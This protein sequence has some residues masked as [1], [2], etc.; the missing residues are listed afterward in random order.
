MNNKGQTT[1]FFTLI[2][3]ILIEITFTAF[4]VS[5]LYIGKMKALACV[6]SMR[7]SIM[8]DYDRELF[9]QYHLLF[10][11]TT[12][13]TESD[14]YLE[15]KIQDYLDASLNGGIG[16]QDGI[17]KFSIEEIGI[18]E[19]TGILEFDMKQL[20]KQIV[21]YEKTAG[22]I[23][24]VSKISEEVKNSSKKIQEAAEETEKSVEEAKTE[25]VEI[26]GEENG[27]EVKDPRD[28]LSA[29]LNKGILS[30]VMPGN[31]FSTEEKIS[32][33]V[34]IAYEKQKDTSFSDFGNLK[35]VLKHSVET[36]QYKGLEENAALLNYINTHFSNGVHPFQDTVL[37]CETEYILKGNSSDYRNMESIA[38]ELIWLRMPI[39]YSYLLSDPVKVEE[40][41][42]LALAIS[43]MTGVPELYMVVEYLLLGCWSYA[44]SIYDVKD[45]LAGNK[46][47][48]VKTSLNWKTDLE[49]LAVVQS[50]K[51]EQG[52]TYEEYL[53]LLLAAK[54]KKEVEDCYV[55]MLEV[56]EVNIQQ[57]NEGFHITNCVGALN[58]QGIVEISSL[59]CS[60]KSQDTYQYYINEHMDYCEDKN[61]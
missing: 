44:E 11:D 15:E 58:I 52:L 3:C 54:S 36:N 37:Q 42:A 60:G 29:M 12:Y 20:K 28:T 34:S 53:L 14:G 6:H 23:D 50:E 56:M 45:L 46:V 22:I 39:N 21:D 32:R 17:Y 1:V 18:S 48:Y 16:E 9:E 27:K 31:T 35:D 40:A 24:G 10:L 43:S 51:C 47:P 55:R 5:R 59:F 8:A 4:E 38:N 19:K 57:E 7:T 41:Q 25:E 26:S 49:N 2:I 30:I 61:P 13:G 33:D